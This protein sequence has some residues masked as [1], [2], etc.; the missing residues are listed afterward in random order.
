VLEQ[1][2]N[3]L[4]FITIPSGAYQLGWRFADRLTAAMV[5]EI[6]DF[7]P[8]DLFLQNFSPPR[9]IHLPTFAIAKTTISI[10]D[11]LGSAYKL[12]NIATIEELCNAIDALLAPV[13]MRLPT[14]D[15]LEAAC[16]GGLFA[17][18]MEIPD[19][20]PYNDLTTF[21]QH[22]EPNQSGLLLNSDPYESEIVRNVLKLG[23]GGV[24]ICGGYPR[25]I[26]WL[27]LSP[28][29]FLDDEYLEGCFPEFMEC[30]SVRPVIISPAAGQE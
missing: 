3:D 18:G 10:E 8:F 1:L 15:E 13:G 17:W 23:D 11:L 16:G 21:T 27:S 14:E 29:W 5:A 2:L 4:E 25:P 26:A 9:D 19:G 12:E 28:S 6:N 7:Y 24:S 30:T 20:I 22:Q